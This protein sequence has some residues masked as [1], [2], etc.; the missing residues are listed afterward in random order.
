MNSTIMS[1]NFKIIQYK[2][3][4]S[5]KSYQETELRGKLLTENRP[6]NEAEARTV[7]ATESSTGIQ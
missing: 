6:E 1:R 5:V 4:L 7:L 2:S 3:R